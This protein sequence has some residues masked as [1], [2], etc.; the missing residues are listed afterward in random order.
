[1][2][3]LVACLLCLT[4]ALPINGQT[5]KIIRGQIAGQNVVMGSIGGDSSASEIEA[6]RNR[7]RQLTAEAQAHLAKSEFFQARDTAMRACNLVVDQP[8]ADELLKILQKL[9]DEGQQQF[10]AASKLYD[11]KQYDQAI[12]Q[13]TVVWQTFNGLPSGQRASEM[14]K[15]AEKEPAVRQF[16][17]EAKASAMLA[18]FDVNLQRALQPATRPASQPTTGPAT[19]PA[20]QPIL[21]DSRVDRILLLPVDKQLEMVERLEQIVHLYAAVPSGQAADKDLK[22]LQAD[23]KLQ[24]S[25][26]HRKAER[27]ADGALSKAD[28]YSTSGLRDKAIE[29]YRDVIQQFPNTPQAAK[30][31]AALASLHAKEKE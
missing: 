18:M 16:L 25:L 21:P 19:A 29:Y 17:Q 31:K 8:S 24:E 15:A 3:I 5:T 10:D 27:Q 12:K 9:Q 7:C 22:A 23:K 1:M 28:M 11:N 26:A 20:S 14:L 30:A 6:T 4:W 13:L 2:R